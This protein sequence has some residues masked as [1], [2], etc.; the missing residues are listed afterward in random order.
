MTKASPTP[1]ETRMG[2]IGMS[3]AWKICSGFH[4]N[5]IFYIPCRAALPPH[6]RKNE[7]KTI[8]G[9]PDSEPQERDF[10]NLSGSRNKASDTRLAGDV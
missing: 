2:W 4:R 1:G 3:P 8:M 10:A 7:G 5:K 9:C 6:W